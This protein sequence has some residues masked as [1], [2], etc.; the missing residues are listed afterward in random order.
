MKH[1]VDTLTGGLLD[2]AVAL[3]NGYELRTALPE[4]RERFGLLYTLHGKGLP[5]RFVAEQTEDGPFV[6]FRPDATNQLS[7]FLCYSPTHDGNLCMDLMEQEGIGV[8]AYIEI[9]VDQTW[10]SWGGGAFYS[11]RNPKVAVCRAYVAEK[12]GEEV[13]L[14]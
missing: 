14:P 13:E 2:A 6:W 7:E 1:R 12:I 5:V 4:W 9:P 8:A 11:G 3:A 10:R